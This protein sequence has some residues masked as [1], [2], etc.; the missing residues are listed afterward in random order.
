M[1]F[2]VQNL[3]VETNLNLDHKGIDMKITPSI[4]LVDDTQSNLDILIDLL[5]S[6][7]LTIALNGHDA[8]EMANNQ[9]FDLILLDIMMPKVDGFEVCHRLK[10][11][12]K[13]KDIP[14]IFITA[15]TDLQSIEK[16]FHY[17]AIDYI[18]KPFMPKEVLSRVTT[19][20]KLHQM[21]HNLETMVQTE[22]KKRE[23]QE[24]ILQQQ[25]KMAAMAEMMDAVAHQW[26]Q[27]LNSLKLYSDLLKG[28]YENGMIDENYIVQFCDDTHMQISHMVDTL[29]EFRTFFRPNK[30]NIDFDLIDVINSV[31]V[32]TK[33]ELL[34]HH[35]KVK[36]EHKANIKL[37]GSD[38]EFKHLI[39]NIINNAKDAFLDTHI[40][41]KQ[42]MIRL[43]D[44]EQGK[45]LEIEDNAGGI[46]EKVLPHIFKANVTSKSEGKGTG[47][48]LY[49]SYQIAEKHAATLCARNQN[50]G[51]CFSIHWF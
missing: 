38:N 17:G 32:L 24:K 26:K 8:M 22:I 27:P 18:A 14:I 40:K 39:L 43:L 33:D 6:Y 20:L 13:T 34:K 36:I 11:N 29:D 44:T 42:I 28:D 3:L 19:H 23:A 7:T 31:L 47:I 1:R 9:Y 16:A 15:K 51:A 49:M 10:Q 4:L 48:G 37:Y 45:L 25:S 5:D 2:I 30:V 46:S 41:N 12:P 50:E 21:M 35:I